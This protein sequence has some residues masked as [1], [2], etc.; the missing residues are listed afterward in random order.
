MSEEKKIWILTVVGVVVMWLE[1]AAFLMWLQ[2]ALYGKSV[3][4]WA[5]EKID[6]WK[7]RKYTKVERDETEEE[8]S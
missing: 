5:K 6:E 3:T 1:Y 7:D 8:E 2:K 4:T